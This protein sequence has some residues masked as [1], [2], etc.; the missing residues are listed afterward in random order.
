MPSDNKATALIFKAFCDENRIAILKRL[1]TGEKCV[2]NMA[3]DLGIAQSSLSYHLKILAE[4]GAIQSRQEGK[5]SHYSI[6][7]EGMDSAQRL[8]AD[9]TIALPAEDCG[10]KRA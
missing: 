3:D 8:L 7:Q 2:C 9:L 1:Q 6:N 4:A 10:C 5:W